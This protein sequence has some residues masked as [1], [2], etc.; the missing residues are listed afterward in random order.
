MLRKN[1][2][3][4]LLKRVP[5]FERCS[6]R[7]L[8]QIAGLAD[9]VHLP[10]GRKLTKEGGRGQEFIVLVEGRAGVERQGRR[11]RDLEAGEFLG[12]IALVADVPRTATVTT[13]TPAE[14]LLMTA[15]DFRTLMRDVPSLQ[16][17]VL[18]ALAMR[19]PPEFQ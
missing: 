16:P 17:K 3:I 10:A 7:E 13:L 2:K 11:L 6:K 19:L 15:R 5:L 1:A 4:E 8:Q 14:I 9:E 12:E 18:Y